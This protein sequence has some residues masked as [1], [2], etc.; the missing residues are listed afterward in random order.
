M[1]DSYVLKIVNDMKRKEDEAARFYDEAAAKLSSPMGKQLFALLAHYEKYHYIKL[2]ELENN[3]QER[4]AY[5]KYE[6]HEVPS[7]PRIV[8]SAEM[9][10]E[11]AEILRII[12]QAIKK[13]QDAEKR[14]L[15]L[16][17]EINDPDGHYMFDRLSEEEHL[18]FHILKGAYWSLKNTDSWEWTVR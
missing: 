7:S 4:S 16:A 1:V 8:F 13:E 3:L 6:R 17:D 2:S 18:H 5:I 9:G 11:K 10:T 14:Y 15:K 12:Q